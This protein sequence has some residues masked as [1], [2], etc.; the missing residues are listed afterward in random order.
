MRR[1]IFLVPLLLAT[2]TGPGRASDDVLRIPVSFEVT[3]T[4]PPGHLSCPADGETYTLPG[5]ITG[6][7]VALESD[8][9]RTISILMSG[10]DTSGE[11]GWMLD[12][13]GYDTPVEM[14]KLG[15]ITLSYD[16]LGYGAAGGPHGWFECF[17]TQASVTHQMVRQ[18]REGTYTVGQAIAFDDVVLVAHDV[19]GAIA[20]IE[21]Y[22][23]KD[24]DGIVSMIWADQGFTPYITTLAAQRYAVCAA[25]GD[26]GVASPLDGYV[27]F[28]PPDDEFRRDLIQDME[29][30]V[31]DEL[32]G[33]RERSPCGYI[34]PILPS[35]AVDKARMAEITVPV[36]LIYQEHDVVISRDGQNQQAA[37]FSGSDDVTTVF[38]DTGHWMMF[39]R[40]AP[41]FR[42]TMS[43][44]LHARY[45]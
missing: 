40:T 45:P 12:F 11:W 33:R 5:H 13:A 16:M 8:G 6:P 42:Q 41:A 20:E 32:V 4:A 2:S 14:A 39:E 29:P 24:V 25:G 30:A 34:Y 18:L 21:A 3:N 9:S 22:V 17:A 43:D 1:A 35:R 26:G 36:L 31:A 44:W 15:H 27:L 7:R 38:L 10:F 37:N 23:Y 19:A 28:G